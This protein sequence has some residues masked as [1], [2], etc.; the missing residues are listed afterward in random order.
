MKRFFFT[1]LGF[2]LYAVDI[3]AQS[4]LPE[5]IRF[6]HQSQ[7]DSFPIT[8]AGC[9]E[10]LGDVNIDTTDIT[11][12][13]SLY[14]I[15]HIHGSLSIRTNEDLRSF[16]GLHNLQVVNG[17]VVIVDNHN[18]QLTSLAGFDNLT[19]VGGR[20]EINYNV[21]INTL[22]NLASL[23]TIQGDTNNKGLQIFGLHGI[24]NLEG[25]E[26]LTEIGGGLAVVHC[27]NVTSLE[28]LGPITSIG[29][30]LDIRGTGISNFSGLEQLTHVGGALLI[31]YNYELTNL[32]A[33]SQLTE[34][35]GSMY[36]EENF[37]LTSISGLENITSPILHARIE[38]N[39]LL[40]YC[41]I[42]PL[43][44][45]L[46]GPG[47][48]IFIFENNAEGC[49]TQEEVESECTG[50]PIKVIVLVDT[51]G[52]CQQDPV[53]L[54]FSEMQVHFDSDASALTRSTDANGV[55]Y[56]TRVDSNDFSLYLPQ[57]PSEHWEACFDTLTLDPTN[58]EDT[59]FATILL[60]PS[61]F[62]PELSTELGLPPA[63]RGCLINSNIQVQI[64]NVGTITAENIQAAVVLP[65]S[66]IELISSSVPILMQNGD[67]IFFSVS[68]LA[69][70][71]STSIDLVVKT[72]CDTF[73]L[74][75]T[76]CVEAFAY[77]ENACPSG[78]ES[79]SEI[80]LYSQ[81]LDDE[82]VRFTIQNVGNAPTQGM[83]EYVIIEDEVVLMTDDFDLE[84]METRIIDVPATGA[85]YRMEATRFPDGT[86][87]AVALENCG[88]LTPGLI[89][90]YWLDEGLENHDF[91]CREV[92][93]A[94]D[95]NQKTAIPKGIGEEHLLSAN[96]TLQYT[97]EFQNTG[98]DTAF[99]VLLTDVL[100]PYLDV[101]TFRPG[102][103]SHD[104]T[105][106][107]KD[108]NKLKVLFFP[109]ALP[110]SNQNLAGSQ[111]FF[112]FNIDQVQDLPDGTVIEN[113][114][115]IVFDYNPPIVTNTVF[116]TIG[117]L[118]VIIDDSEHETDPV[119]TVFANPVST[120]A[121]FR[122]K[123]VIAGEKR[124]E[125]F[126]S[127]GRLVRTHRFEGQEF[128]FERQELLGGMY[129]FKITGEQGK[130]ATGKVVIAY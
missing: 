123:K 52:D 36:I 43:C 56:F 25:L 74:G 45:A 31:G 89:T 85:T 10:V 95:P 53:N 125:L 79:F 120:T 9:H 128:L 96:R 110:D 67:T 34:I 13:D 30:D 12:L 116:H 65:S 93:L 117:E 50:Q 91:D 11:N 41:A 27:Q 80:R 29:G 1:L 88:G 19:L 69:F 100:S 28:A 14:L 121:T 107:I 112:T 115:N 38:K 114:A 58:L 54:P 127:S 55:V 130:S 102:S 20:L 103:A 39:S 21:N 118:L 81:C 32:D 16:Q 26:N 18:N 15:T 109:I 73:L 17:S 51:D 87:T 119:W 72:R 4:C 78:I 66:A 49:N 84:P 77:P 83:H 90:A 47:E 3:E 75:Q 61:S 106:E 122:T 33:L 35:N 76:L 92:V 101:A 22:S 64:Q 60:S 8:Y 86:Q 37:A 59:I 48:E 44:N 104:Y 2:L 23:T 124:F 129:F 82:T 105:W 98:T 71:E 5:G 63:F 99:R 7:V 62:C 6:T 94:Y 108:N 40:T 111:G 97:I 57:T 113:T 46:S 42:A 70:F 126:D 24:Q 68:N